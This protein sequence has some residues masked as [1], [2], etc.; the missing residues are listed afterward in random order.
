MK[1]PTPDS[2][3]GGG[4]GGGASG[5]QPSYIKIPAKYNNKNKSGLKTTL[6]NGSNKYS[7]DLTDDK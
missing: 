5:A 4:G 7:P 1:G 2:Y 6:T 3:Q